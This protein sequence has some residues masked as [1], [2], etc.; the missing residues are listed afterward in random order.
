MTEDPVRFT[1]R[2]FMNLPSELLKLQGLRRKAVARTWMVGAFRAYQYE[3]MARVRHSATK[4]I[5]A[6]PALLLNRGLVSI[7]ARSLVRSTQPITAGAK[8]SSDVASAENCF[9][10]PVSNTAE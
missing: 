3:D 8:N 1:N 5:A 6:A 10:V 4:A 7:L 2:V 9:C